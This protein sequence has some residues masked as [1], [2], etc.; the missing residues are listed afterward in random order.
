MSDFNYAL[1]IPILD[2]IKSA[3]EN[4]KHYK[5]FTQRAKPF[6]Q[7]ALPDYTIHV[8]VDK[9]LSLATSY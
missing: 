5:E 4:F 3:L 7:A 8:G 9:K 6:L 2:G 1:H